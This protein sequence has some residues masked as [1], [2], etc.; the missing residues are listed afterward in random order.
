MCAHASSSPHTNV[1]AAMPVVTQRKPKD[2]AARQ[3]VM[4]RSTLRSH[5]SWPLP[6]LLADQLC[7]A[8]TLGMESSGFLWLLGLERTH[9]T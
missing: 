3:A 8:M 6:P 2:P 9:G 7:D 5:G 4:V 1:L